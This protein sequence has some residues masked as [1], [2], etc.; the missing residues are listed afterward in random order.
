MASDK[1]YIS[2]RRS[3]HLTSSSKACSGYALP[4]MYTH[5]WRLTLNNQRFS[6][7]GLAIG[8]LVGAAF[9]L[10]G[11]LIAQIPGS[12]AMGPVMFFLVPLAAGFAIAMVTQG[13]QRMATAALLATAISL[14]LLIT[15]GMET[16]LCA[17]LVIPLLFLGLMIGVGV[18]Y[19]F[20]KFMKSRSNGSTLKSIVILSVPLLVLS[21]HRIE[22][23]TLTHPRKETVTSAVWLDAMPDQ[24]WTTLQTFDGL[25]AKKL[26]LMYIGLPIPIRC[27]MQGV[28]MGA[29]R[30]CYFDK[31]YIQETITGWTPPSQM[32][33]LV[34]RTNLPG[35]HWLGF[36]D[37]EY[38]L[39]EPNGGTILTRKTTIISNLYPAAY[40][41]PFERWGVASEHEYIFR[42]L[43]GLLNH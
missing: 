21:G 25:K 28:G 18:A 8:T 24:V 6:I 5:P 31:G 15:S 27:T 43:E 32:K 22:L 23:E 36:E 19:L 3:D 42:D 1:E 7:K 17:V 20:Q 14:I 26:A 2:D 39:Q 16:F 41:R 9:G 40:W 11:F 37:A 38:D 29:T 35:R 13:I 4:W 12:N 33:L 34:D 10:G 30:T